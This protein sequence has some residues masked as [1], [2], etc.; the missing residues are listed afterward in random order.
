MSRVEGCVSS[1]VYAMMGMQEMLYQWNVWTCPHHEWE[2]HDLRCL[3]EV[4]GTKE[5]GR[6]G[7]DLLCQRLLK[8]PQEE[9]ILEDLLRRYLLDYLPLVHSSEPG[10]REQDRIDKA[11]SPPTSPSGIVQ[12][13]NTQKGTPCKYLV[14][15]EDMDIL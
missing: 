11:L 8:T 4:T 2:A 10:V 12:A 15:N 7:G 6:K 3:S 1:D 13:G 14:E 5:R 9:Q